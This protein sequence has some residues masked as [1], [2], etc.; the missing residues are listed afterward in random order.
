MKLEHL[1]NNLYYIYFIHINWLT[2]NCIDMFNLQRMNY[3]P[4]TLTIINGRYGL[5]GL[6]QNPGSFIA[7]ILNLES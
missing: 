1:D 4:M 7:I 3:C 5:L 6:L 2:I